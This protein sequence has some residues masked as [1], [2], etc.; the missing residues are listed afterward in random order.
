MN[1]ALVTSEF[2]SES[3]YDGGLANYTYRLAKGLK[4]FNHRPVVFVRSETTEK[5]IFDGIE[6]YRV[7]MRN[8][9]EWLY[10]NKYLCKPYTVIK[11]SLKERTD[12]WIRFESKN[13][14]KIQSMKLNE[15]VKKIH[16]EIHF[17]I[18]HYSALGGTGL[19]RPNNIP[20][21]SR[22]SGSNAMAH[23][24]G[25]YGE[26]LSEIMQQEKIELKALKKMDANFGPSKILAGMISKKINQEIKIIETLY[27]NDVEKEDSSVY[28]AQLKGKKYLLFF[29]TI[30]LIKGIGTVARIIHPFLEKHKDYYFVF[31]GKILHSEEEGVNMMDFVKKKAGEYKDRVIHIGK[32]PHSTLYPII[33]K[34]E[35]I[36]SPSRIDN[37]PNTCIEAM[38]NGKIVIGTL[39]N[40]F[41]QMIDHKKSGFLIPVD[42]YQKL[43]ECMEE[44]LCLKP[45]EKKEME[46]NALAR[47]KKLA[48]ENIIPQLIEFY[49]QAINKF[50]GAA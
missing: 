47:M 43:L 32:T 50:K 9:D 28:E 11:R 15:W 19:H 7:D 44:I 12:W 23:D 17:D 34:A 30:G 42:D 40:G 6:V 24:F 5:I 36:V 8:W 21:I 29:G 10:S 18:I 38:V 41:E 27:V 45:E 22:L 3:N 39:G 20:C 1:I 35:F 4:Q 13:G 25:G 26:K 46:Q 16:K 49:Q 33:K 14:L 31:V 2:L 48:P 37:F